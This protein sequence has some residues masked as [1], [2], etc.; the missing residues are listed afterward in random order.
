[1][2]DVESMQMEYI[3]QCSD[4]SNPSDVREGQ[5]PTYENNISCNVSIAISK[6]YIRGS[7][8]DFCGPWTST[9]ISRIR[10]GIQRVQT[11]WWL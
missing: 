2:P 8:L 1:M 10:R 3:C 11:T 7:P 4:C 9:A 6:S 5:C